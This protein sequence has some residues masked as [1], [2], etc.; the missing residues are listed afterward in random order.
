[1][2]MR[3]SLLQFVTA[4]VGVTLLAVA[5][6]ILAH[7]NLAKYAQLQAQSSNSSVTSRQIRSE[8]G[9]LPLS[10]EANMGQTA[11]E[12]QFLSHGPGYELFLTRQEAVLALRRGKAT[13][14]PR[15]NRARYLSELRKAERTAKSS[16]L[17]LQFA[18]AN[19]A[20]EISGVNRLPGRTDYFIGNDPRNWRTGVPSYGKVAYRGLYSGIDAVFYGNQ[21]QLEYDFVVS[22][23]ADPKQIAL[24]VDGANALKIDAQ[25]SLVMTVAGGD[26]D[27]LKPTVY[28]DIN[29]QRK[30]IAA[31]YVIGSGNRVSFSLAGYD[32]SQPLVIDPV[33]DYSTYLGGSAGNAVNGVDGAFGIAVDSNGD[34]YVAGQTFSLSFP[35]LNGYTNEPVL[36]NPN[37]AV[38]VTELNPTGTALVYSTY[39]I[40]T[41]ALGDFGQAVALDSSGNI[42]VTGQTFS[43]QFPVTANAAQSAPTNG[44]TLGSAFISKINPSIHGTGSLVYSSYLGGSG[45]DG[46]TGVAADANGNAYVV[47]FTSS[48]DFLSTVTTATGYQTT[49]PEQPNNMAAYGA[50]FLAAVNTS[51][52]SV[53]YSTYLGGTGANAANADYGDEALGVAV[54]S[55]QN[56]Y[57]A[58]TTSSTNF[59]VVNGIGPNTT[60]MTAEAFVSVIYTGNATGKTGANSLIYSTYLGGE[61]F[62]IATAVALEPKNNTPANAVYVTGQ[63]AST[64]FPVTTGAYASTI[65][66]N[67][68][69]FAT[70]LDTTQSGTMSLKYS[71]VVGGSGGDEGYGIQADSSGNA[72][73][74]GTTASADFPTTPGAFQ[75][76]ENNGAG[77]AFVF[78]INPGGNG[79]ADLFYSTYFGGSGPGEDTGAAIALGPSNNVYITGSTGSTTNFPIYPPSTATPP[80]FQT[81][82]TGS[83]P[84]AT[85]AAYVAELTL[86]PTITFSATTLAFGDVTVGTTATAC[87]ALSPCVVTLTNNT[88]AA[89]PITVGAITPAGTGF[90]AAP[91]CGTPAVV[92]PGTVCTIAVT[93]TPTSA[94]AEVGTLPISF[95]AGNNLVP[96]TQNITL[97]GTGTN[98]TVAPGSLTFGFQLITS[99]SAP[100]MQVTLTNPSASPVAFTESVSTN[101]GESD[102]CGGM[103]PANNVPCVLN[104]TF[105]PSATGPL[106]GTLTV[107]SGGVN[108]TVAL[109]GSGGDFSVTMPASI[110][111]TNGSGSGSATLTWTS[112]FANPPT[113]SFSCTTTITNGSC[114][115]G[116]P[117]GNGSFTINVSVSAAVPPANRR[118]DGWRKPI[119]PLAVAILA[120]LALPLLRRRRAWLGFAAVVLGCAL[121]S[122]CS[123]THTPKTGTLTLTGSA[124]SGTTTVTHTFNTSVTVQ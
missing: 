56:A 116:T 64:K 85:A 50:A 31:N 32:A 96:N 35:T 1:M 6:L 59:P 28:Q 46:G 114:T 9:R 62:D 40:A 86:Q 39:L 119:V 97:T 34:A 71:A 52:G 27:L 77:T 42:Y 101:F 106:T 33:L 84:A 69:A 41:D 92:V 13:S 112:G 2:K 102:T 104:V 65:T 120:L 43:Q 38:F 30:E 44:S 105:T 3:A 57:I 4:L 7:R 118:F 21:R 53:T 55:S 117:N 67:G 11:P 29:G 12:V 17:R 115:A 90:A 82:L 91:S 24:N 49:N 18:G 72:Y 63:T 100:P 78:E 15:S 89:I 111:V 10:F 81:K 103:V 93:F 37:G 73:V 75:T 16:V 121:F 23:G 61:V 8:Y 58:G 70:I 79:N 14:A 48:L 25:G 51:S 54:D 88:N 26:V 47:G 122:A 74:A 19:P 22:P 36:S 5:G 98:F 94:A 99:T 108:Q 87:G 110:T 76:A 60:N 107:T 45:G 95:T 123:G 124:M 109:S 113:V 68:V 66:A 83:D 80:A 20:A